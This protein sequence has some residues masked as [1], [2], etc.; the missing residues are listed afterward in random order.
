MKFDEWVVID[1]KI[2]GR[3]IFDIVICLK[4]NDDSLIKDIKRMIKNVRG[5]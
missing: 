3:K 2:R 1:V 4:N 5:Y